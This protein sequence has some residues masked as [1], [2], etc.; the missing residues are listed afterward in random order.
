MRL[1]P[2]EILGLFGLLNLFEPPPDHPD[3]DL[4][5]Q[6]TQHKPEQRPDQTGFDTGQIKQGTQCTPPNP[7]NCSTA[8]TA[9]TI[10]REIGKKTFQP[11]RMSWS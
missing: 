2:V 4:V 5:I 1:E 8:A 3:Y 11:R 6:I 7:V 10:T 9:T